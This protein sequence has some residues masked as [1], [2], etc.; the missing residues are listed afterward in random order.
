MNLIGNKLFLFNVIQWQT[1]YFIKLRVGNS[2]WSISEQPY[3]HDL[4][5]SGLL[6][7]ISGLLL[8]I[9]WPIVVHFLAYCCAFSGLFLCISGLLLCIS[10][11][12]KNVLTH[13]ILTLDESKFCRSYSVCS[14]AHHI[15]FKYRLSVE[16]V[17]NGFPV[18]SLLI[19]IKHMI[20]LSRSYF[21]DKAKPSE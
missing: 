7:C 2:N 19:N 10:K 6:L 16:K 3:K 4:W 1:T 8:C 9:F 18:I 11:D 12:Q 20:D 15:F 5:Y 13:F 21:W 17:V 14:E